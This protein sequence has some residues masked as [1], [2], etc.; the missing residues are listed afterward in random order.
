MKD[1]VCR[2]KPFCSVCYLLF[3]H[4][5]CVNIFQKRSHACKTRDV[6]S[7]YLINK[8]TIDYCRALVSAAIENQY[9]LRLT[10]TSDR[11][12]CSTVSLAS[13]HTSHRIQLQRT[14]FGLTAYLIHIKICLS[15]EGQLWREII[16][17][18]EN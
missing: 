1:Y 2:A 5:E 4:F 9:L 6:I 10:C 11:A 3:L 18:S 14:V 8:F 17:V 16:N 7:L 12:P 15:Y 13:A